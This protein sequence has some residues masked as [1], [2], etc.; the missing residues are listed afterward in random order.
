MPFPL[1]FDGC[2]VADS[3]MRIHI[4]VYEEWEFADVLGRR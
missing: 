4:A 2:M 3:G 1:T